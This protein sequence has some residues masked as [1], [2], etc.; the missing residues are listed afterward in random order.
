[1][2]SDELGKSPI[3]NLA[4][5]IIRL[6]L[7]KSLLSTAKVTMVSE[8]GLLSVLVEI[9][10]YAACNKRL[11][12]FTKRRLK[13]YFGITRFRFIRFSFSPFLID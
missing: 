9:T 6:P 4:R 2:I 10:K 5:R 8:L 1:M 7:G 11:V 13:I 3:M 12:V